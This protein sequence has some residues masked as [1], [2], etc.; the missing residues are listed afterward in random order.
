MAELIKIFSRLGVP[1]TI[2]TDASLTFKSELV[3]CLEQKLCVRPHISTP[4]HRSSQGTVERYIGTLKGQLRKYM[5]DDPRGWDRMLPYL[6]F[7]YREVPCETTGF[8]PFVL[9]YGRHIRGPLQILRQQMTQKTVEPMRKQSAIKY[10][11]D[12]QERLRRSAEL[13]NEKATKER[14]RRKKWYDKSSRKRALVEGQKVLILYLVIRI[15]MASWEGSL[16]VLR[17][18]N[19]I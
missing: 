7:A 18:V 12:R 17:R 13:A 14:V 10:L 4:Y 3:T 1:R 19:E 11:L 5:Q 15:L 8:S 9:L 6:L 2:R 16:T